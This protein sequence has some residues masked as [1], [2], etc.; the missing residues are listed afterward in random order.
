MAKSRT[1]AFDVYVE[2]VRHAAGTAES[3]LPKGVEI[4]NPRAWDDFDDPAASASAASAGGPPPKSGR[5]SGRDAWA[6][7]AEAN[8]VEVTEADSKDDVI[9]ACEAAGVPVE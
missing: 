4:T 5:G 2:G 7:Y 8:G 1:L 9:A 6:D 3:D